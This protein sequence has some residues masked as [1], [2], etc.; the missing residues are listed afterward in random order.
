MNVKIVRPCA[1]SPDGIHVVAY[2]KG[3]TVDLPD[4]LAEVFVQQGWAGIR[5]LRKAKNV[6]KAPENKMARS[7]QKRHSRRG[8]HGA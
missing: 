8:H 2:Q 3:E 5:V 6:G 4:S 1:G 7:R